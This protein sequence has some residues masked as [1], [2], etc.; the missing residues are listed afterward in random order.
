MDAEQQ[1]DAPRTAV[2]PIPHGQLRLLNTADHPEWMLDESTRAVGRRGVAQAR[3]ALRAARG[4]HAASADR[5]APTGAASS[6]R[7]TAA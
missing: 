7:S 3:A 5:P 6:H 2:E 1:H 4:E